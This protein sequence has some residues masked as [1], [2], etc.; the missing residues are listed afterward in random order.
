MRTCIPLIDCII[1]YTIIFLA[2]SLLV[3]RYGIILSIWSNFG[4]IESLTYCPMFNQV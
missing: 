1:F 2:Y 4:N 3:S